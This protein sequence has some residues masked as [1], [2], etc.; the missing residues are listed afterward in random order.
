MKQLLG[1]IAVVVLGIATILAVPFASQPAQAQ[2]VNNFTI[3][4]Y[5]IAYTLSRDESNRSVLQTAE[6][7]TALF[8]DFDQNH[9]IERMIPKQYN[10]P[11]GT[12]LGAYAT[13]ASATR[14]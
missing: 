7:I 1:G 14:V 13:P 12:H 2:N 3:N 11:L 9:G 10:S 8:P 6:V 5:D 4:A